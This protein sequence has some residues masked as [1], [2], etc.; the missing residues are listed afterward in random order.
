MEPDFPSG[1]ARRGRDGW[2]GALQRAISGVALG[3][4]GCGMLVLAQGQPAW[5]DGQF[6]PGL[7][8]RYLAVGVIGLGAVWAVLCVRRS[9][10]RASPSGC[11]SE[12]S[13]IGSGL[14][15]A[16]PALLGAVLLFATSLPFLGLVLSAG[17][18]GGLTAWGAGESALRPL[19]VTVG[20]LMGLVTL[21]GL[22]LLPPTAPLW[23]V[24]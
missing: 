8:A 21:V 18:A 17:L 16:A 15:R 9:G 24:I 6:G 20:G 2:R 3:S 5:F 1:I 11:G 4:L 14:G 22:L 23:P 10:S 7:L 19:C 12:P 13:A